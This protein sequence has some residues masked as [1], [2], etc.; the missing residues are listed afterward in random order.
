MPV[1]F[2]HIATTPTVSFQS[3]AF[4]LLRGQPLIDLPKPHIKSEKRRLRRNQVLSDFRYSLLPHIHLF[5]LLDD[6]FLGFILLVLLKLVLC[7]LIL[8]HLIT[9]LRYI[10]DHL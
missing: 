5:D 2:R 10:V 6:V 7:S 3:V 8:L 4:F 9:G 1:R